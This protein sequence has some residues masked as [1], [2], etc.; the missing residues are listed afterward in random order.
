MTVADQ[1]EPRFVDQ[2]GRLQGMSWSFVDHLLRSEL[3]EFLV[4]ERQQFFSGLGLPLLHAIQAAR[5]LAH[6]RIVSAPTGMSIS[7]CLR[8]VL[9]AS[10][11]R[12]FLRRGRGKPAP[13]WRLNVPVCHSPVSWAGALRSRPHEADRSWSPS[14]PSQ[15]TWPGDTA[16]K[17]GCTTRTRVRSL[18]RAQAIPR[19]SIGP[20]CDR[21]RECPS[22]ASQTAWAVGLVSGCA[23]RVAPGKTLIGLVNL[24][25]RPSSLRPGRAALDAR[26]RSGIA[27]FRARTHRTHG[28]SR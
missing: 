23:L 21:S 24:A 20:Q 9:G 25:R 10:Q 3:P 2:R 4:D 8:L 12:R 1:L 15:S 19:C 18:N 7:V 14:R 28:A 27:R 26:R 13:G 11:D 5:D 6:K 16:T 22:S 17:S